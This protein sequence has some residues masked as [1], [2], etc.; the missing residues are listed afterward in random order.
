MNKLDQLAYDSGL[1]SQGTPDEWD[2]DALRKYGE[3]VVRLCSDHIL[4]SSDRYRK[5]HFA[6]K[7]LELLNEPSG[8]QGNNPSQ[9]L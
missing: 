3:A 9:E 8:I 6:Q 1:Y 2:M 5:E 7:V 4:T